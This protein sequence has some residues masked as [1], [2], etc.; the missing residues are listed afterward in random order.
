M[1]V[2]EVLLT[3]IHKALHAF[4]E[5]AALLPDEPR[6]NGN[7]RGQRDGDKLRH[8]RQHA[9]KQE[10]AAVAPA[11]EL[12]HRHQLAG[13]HDDAWLDVQVV[14][15]LHQNPVL[16]RILMEKQDALLIQLLHIQLIKRGQRVIPAHA[17]DQFVVGKDMGVE[18]VC[19]GV[20]HVDDAS[21]Q[22]LIHHQ[23][24]G[25][26]GAEF[27]QHEPHVRVLR[28]KGFQQLRKENHGEHWRD[29]DAD[30]RL[31]RA[32][33]LIVRMQG[34]TGIENLHRAVIEGVPLLGQR[35]ASASIGKQRHGELLL[36]LPDGGRNGGLCHEHLLRGAGDA[37]IARSTSEI[38]QLI[39]R[40]VLPSHK[41]ILC[42]H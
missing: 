5:M 18:L 40:H 32:P 17:E 16:Y 13:V 31:D 30:L 21:V 34:V 1:A 6:P 3:E 23:R 15:A 20:L 41:S 36:Q 2:T 12:E 19:A 39:E 11:H 8:H 10:A 9:F 7:G 4:V 28:V 24:A 35:D 33:V 26:H 14:K 37:V 22:Q 29:A 27:L 42:L 38:A 25:A